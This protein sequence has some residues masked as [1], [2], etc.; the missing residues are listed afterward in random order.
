MSGGSHLA[1]IKTNCFVHSSSYLGRTLIALGGIRETQDP[2]VVWL[3]SAVSRNP[4]I[5]L[6]EEEAGFRRLRYGAR[7]GTENTAAKCVAITDCSK[8]CNQTACGSQ[9]IMGCKFMSPLGIK[10]KTRF[11]ITCNVTPLAS[12]VAKKKRSRPHKWSPPQCWM[13]VAQTKRGDHPD[14][15]K[16]LS[17]PPSLRE[18][19][20]GQGRISKN[21]QLLIG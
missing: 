8:H 21:N 10:K 11:E 1:R 6:G 17:E 9:R 20:G 18:R 2:V 4:L 15:A 13:A 7:A 16:T 5:S 19:G 14:F 3:W 12:R